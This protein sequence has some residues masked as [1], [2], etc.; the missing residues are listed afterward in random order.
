MSTVHEILKSRFGYDSFRP[1]Q[2]S[3]VNDVVSGT[4]TLVIMPTGGGKSLCYQV[5]ALARSGCAIVVSP[6]I[7]LMQDQVNALTQLGINAAFINSSLDHRQVYAIEQQMRRGELD[8]VYMAPERLIMPATIELLKSIE[9]AL[10][11]IDEA[12]CVS[13]WGH[14]F[15]SDYLGLSVLIEQF[16]STPRIALTA[17]ADSRTRQEIIERL[18]LQTGK[19][20]VTGFDRPNIRYH[21]EL[22]RNARQQLLKLIKSSHQ[23][24]AGV[25]YCMSRAKVEDTAIWLQGE[26]YKAL[27]YHAGLDASIRA[28]NQ[29]RFLREDGVIMVATIAFGMGI[30]KPDVRFVAH[31]DMPKTVE[32]Y[33][34]ETGRAGRDGEPAS[35]YMLYGLQDVIKLRQ[36]MLDSAGSE[37]HKRAEQQRLNAM[38][39]LCEITSCRRQA[40]LN[41]FGEYQKQPCG[42][43]D[44][45]IDPPPTW[46]ATEAAQKALS[47]TYRSGQRFGVSHLV[48]ILLGNPTQKIQQ[49]GHD[50][51]PTFGVGK[52]LDADQWRSVF[53][54]LV[55]RGYIDVDMARYGALILNERCRPLLKGEQTIEM[56]RDVKSKTSTAK[57]TRTHL[58]DD[59]DVGMWEALRTCRRELADEQNVPPYVVFNDKTLQ[60]MARIAPRSYAEMASISGVGDR[61]LEKYGA[62]FMRVINKV[63]GQQ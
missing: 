42:N 46:E 38:L 47:A 44:T 61:K 43:C 40:L 7:A 58:P 37:D 9:L 62:E 31:L 15:R 21:I 20:Y 35:A 57:R 28:N 60:E 50:K 24:D 4:H 59:I 1:A 25:I 27:P 34:Q 33:Y 41:Y 2:E 3:I 13:Q 45:C 12:H 63:I 56:R 48:D 49:F 36:M 23:Q 22:K 6:L 8:I 29:A 10:F 39:G 11:A 30:D 54:Q 17:T 14:D 26:G 52:D 51:L 18:G 5:P 32:A 16:P 19:H 53:R 55:A